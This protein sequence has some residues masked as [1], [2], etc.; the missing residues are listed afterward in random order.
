[1]PMLADSHND[2]ARV[3]EIKSLSS[4][5]KRHCALTGSSKGIVYN[6]QLCHITDR[7]RASPSI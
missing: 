3:E 5:T 7:V 6:A 1:M 4:S 2:W